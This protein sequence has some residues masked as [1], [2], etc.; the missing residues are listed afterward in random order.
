IRLPNNPLV[1]I[2]APPPEFDR[3]T[4]F[5][6]LDRLQ[7]A[8]FTAIYPTHF[9][10][11]EDVNHQ[12]DTIRVLLDE[13]TTFIHDKIVTGVPRDEMVTLY[14]NWVRERGRALGLS[15]EQLHQYEMANPLYMSV[16]GIL[17]YWRK[18]A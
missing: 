8:N 11:L 16:D 2:P 9:G 17:R 4:W 14:E 10:R 5:T 3:E 13:V 15:E 18:R 12:L 6:T 7:A 1:D